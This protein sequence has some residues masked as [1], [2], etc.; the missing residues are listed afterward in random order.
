[1]PLFYSPI[2][3]FFSIHCVTPM[4][5]NVPWPLPRNQ[6]PKIRKVLVRKYEDA[7]NNPSVNRWPDILLPISPFSS[8]PCFSLI[9]YVR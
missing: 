7:W 9:A 6:E 1:M 8:P 3:I 2:L 4:L 5:V